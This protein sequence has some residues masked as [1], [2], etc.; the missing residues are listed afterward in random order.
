[1]SFWVRDGFVKY[2]YTFSESEK[3][4]ESVVPLQSEEEQDMEIE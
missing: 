4:M 1:M 3:L 2:T